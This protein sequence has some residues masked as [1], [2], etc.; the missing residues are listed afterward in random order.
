MTGEPDQTD[1]SLSE[2]LERLERSVAALTNEIVAIRATIAFGETRPFSRRDPLPLRPRP[3][4]PAPRRIRL[5]GEGL[6]LERLLGRYGM[7]GIAVLAAA[8]AVGTF[9][10][11]AISRG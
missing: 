9:L 1:S 10:S 5:P 2:R 3:P 4:Q 6:D 8:A 11:W 7:L